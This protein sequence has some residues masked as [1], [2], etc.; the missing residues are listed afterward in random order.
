[1]QFWS[2]RSQSCHGSWRFSLSNDS[3]LTVPSQTSVCSSH[4]PCL[5]LL[6]ALGAKP[7][8]SSGLFA[9][10]ILLQVKA[11]LS[12]QLLP[13]SS[14]LPSLMNSIFFGNHKAVSLP[15]WV[16]HIFVLLQLFC[17]KQHLHKCW[18]SYVLLIS[19][20]PTHILLSPG[21]FYWPPPPL[22][23][24]PLSIV[25]LLAP[26]LNSPLHHAWVTFLISV[27]KCNR[28]RAGTIFI[29][30]IISL[31]SW[32]S[33]TAGRQRRSPC[34]VFEYMDT[35]ANGRVKGQRRTGREV[36]SLKWYAFTLNCTALITVA[37]T[38]V[39]LSTVRSR[40][41]LCEDSWVKI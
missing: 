11:F 5:R 34:I 15:S 12:T 1:M 41:V 37:A 24:L 25:S 39:I 36:P 13:T 2:Q 4:S 18:R 31:I 6:Q 26:K 8:L 14:K 32:K 29:I 40:M 33:G 35:W 21:G 27:I 7:T 17:S 3:A 30:F 9:L 10:Q 19:H 38:A 16:S 23:R 22:Q 20:I 28:T